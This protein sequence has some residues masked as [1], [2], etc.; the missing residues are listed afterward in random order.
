VQLIAK[1]GHLDPWRFSGNGVEDLRAI[2]NY[3]VAQTEAVKELKAAMGHILRI[4]Q[5]AALQASDESVQA[6]IAI[7]ILRGA[8]G[9]TALPGRA[10]HG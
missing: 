2:V 7:A 3:A 1:Q 6:E 4:P 5:I 9:R 10:P 8:A